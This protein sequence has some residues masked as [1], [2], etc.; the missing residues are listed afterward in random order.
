MT[1]LQLTM[2]CPQCGH[3]QFEMPENPQEYD[4]VK[5]NFCNY[6]LTVIALREANQEQIMAAAKE[7]AKK[8]IEAQLK[9]L[10]KR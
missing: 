10:K 2:Q 6:E 1:T 9:K 4:L 3:E 8:A 5:C 7:H